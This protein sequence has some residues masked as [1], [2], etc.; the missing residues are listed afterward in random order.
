MDHKL[1]SG[2]LEGLFG[3]S[4]KIIKTNELMKKGTSWQN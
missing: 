4:Y 1:I 2:F 3:P